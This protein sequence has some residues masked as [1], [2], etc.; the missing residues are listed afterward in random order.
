MII[1][2]VRWPKTLPITFCLETR[3]ADKDKNATIENP[4]MAQCVKSLSELL[5]AFEKS[6]IYDNVAPEKSQLR[7]DIG[8]LLALCHAAL[9]TIALPPTEADSLEAA[10][11]ALTKS[12]GTFHAGLT[13]YPVGVYMCTKASYMISQC[14]Q[15]QVLESDIDTA[16]EIAKT[17]K[18]NTYKDIAK[19]KDNDLEI[20]ISSQSKFYDMVAKVK[21]FV[22]SASD[23]LKQSKKSEVE[24]I[25][26]LLQDLKVALMDLVD[27]KYVNKFSNFDNYMQLLIEGKMTDEQANLCLQDLNA[28]VSY[29]AVNKGMVLKLLGKDDA[30]SFEEVLGCMPKV[31]A[32]IHKALPNLRSLK[33]DTVNEDVLLNES[34]IALFASLNDL[35][36]MQNLEGIV[37]TWTPLFAKLKDFMKGAVSDW[38]VRATSTFRPFIAKLMQPEM[39]LDA[40]KTMLT[41]DIVG[42]VDYDADEKESGWG[43]ISRFQN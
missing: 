18:I 39:G 12:K 15:D 34:I 43:L 28:I 7:D 42:K 14:R 33:S 38:L 6:K 32:L 22:E 8:R 1:S 4:K 27:V 23:G 30:G 21:V 17:Y 16:V 24:T 10:R 3:S 20:A 35:T 29:Q 40:A 5:I 26:A 37:K 25:L 41:T 31:A 19:T 9:R 11:T 13:M 2:H 36:L